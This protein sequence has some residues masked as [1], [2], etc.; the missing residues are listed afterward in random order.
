M[1]LSWLLNSL[2][3]NIRD[4]V[5]FCEQASDMWKEF[6]ERYGHWNKAR[7][8]Q[9]QKEVSCISEGDLDITWYFNKATKVWDEF[10]AVGT[11]PR[12]TCGKCECD[13][14]SKL[15]SNDQE[16]RLIQFLMGLNE[17]YTRITGDMLMMKP[18]PTLSQLY[19][20]LVQEEKQRQVTLGRHFQT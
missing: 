19:S 6:N 1:V 7:I 16:Q 9:A 5:L 10:V 4:S 14:N 20:L 18:L 15:Q 13:V 12:Y 2:H 3:K 11:T 8:F 17:N